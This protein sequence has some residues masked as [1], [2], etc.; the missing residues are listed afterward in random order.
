MSVQLN[1][2]IQFPARTY[3]LTYQG[4]WTKFTVPGMDSRLW[5]GPQIQSESNCGLGR[6]FIVVIKQYDQGNL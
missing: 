4:I 1:D 6:G 3:D 5:G 2:S